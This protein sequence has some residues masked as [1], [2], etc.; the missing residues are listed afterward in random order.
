M[1]YL[2]G[3]SEKVTMDKTAQLRE[4]IS[5]KKLIIAPGIFD[6]LSARLVEQAGFEALYASGGAIARSTGVPDIGLLSLTEVTDRLSQICAV[7]HRPVIADA[8]TGFGNNLNVRRTVSAFIRAGVA[9]L[10]LED[11]RVHKRWG[12]LDGKS[13]VS[14]AEMVLVS[15]LAV[16]QVRLLLAA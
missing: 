8:D 6:G 1:H 7:T 13:L 2:Q 12:H 15:P 16:V 14:T 9:A 3:C 11:Q 5:D 10:H 4:L